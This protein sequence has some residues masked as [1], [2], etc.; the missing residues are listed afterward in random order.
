M[1]TKDQTRAIG[2]ILASQNIRFDAVDSSYVDIHI[3]L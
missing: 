1:L 3:E 2:Y